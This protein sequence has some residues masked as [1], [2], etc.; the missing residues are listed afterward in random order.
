MLHKMSI[1]FKI[2]WTRIL[3]QGAPD[4]PYVSCTRMSVYL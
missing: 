4:T 1:H 2:Y 3:Y